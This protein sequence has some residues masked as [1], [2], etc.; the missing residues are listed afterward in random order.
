MYLEIYDVIAR[1]VLDSRGN[2]TVEVEVYLEDD[3]M[4]FKALAFSYEKS[5]PNYLGSLFSVDGLNGNVETVAGRETLLRVY[6]EQNGLLQRETYKSDHVIVKFPLSTG[7]TCQ[8]FL[9]QPAK[10]GSGG[11]WCTER[12]MD[13]NGTIYYDIPSTDGRITE[14]YSLLQKE[15]DNGHKPY[16]LDPVQVALEYINGEKGIGQSVSID[17]LEIIN[18]AT[19]KEFLQ[20]PMS[21]YIGFI[22]NF[23][24]DDMTKPYFHLDRIEWLTIEDTKRLNDLGIDPDDLPNGF[25]I[26]NPANYPAYFQCYHD[27]EFLIIDYIPGDHGVSHKSVSV[28]EFAEYLEQFND[29]IPPFHVYTRDGH[30]QTVEEQYVP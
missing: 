16:L 26:Y 13:G 22:S 5:Y 3:T 15:C 25:Y 9:S 19:I 2:P 17:L 18:D 20:T 30:V 21:H 14:Y 4:G 28:T 8:L 6:L 10:I 12:W 1:E 29:F 7:E 24:L 27:T 11:I 23:T